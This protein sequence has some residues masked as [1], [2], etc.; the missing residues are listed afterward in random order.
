MRDDGGRERVLEVAAFAEAD[1][2]A[3]RS[4]GAGDGVVRRARG[5]AAGRPVPPELPPLVRRVDARGELPRP[6]LCRALPAARVPAG[7]PRPLPAGRVLGDPAPGLLGADACGCSPSCAGWRACRCSGTSP[8]RVLGGVPLL[9]AVAIFAVSGWPTRYGAEVKPYSSDLFVALALSALADRVVAEARAG[10]LAL[11]PGGGGADGPGLLVPG[12]LRGRGDRPGPA[13]PAWRARAPGRLAAL[14][15]VRPGPGAATFLLLLHTY[16]TAPQDHAYFHA[17]LGRGIPAARRRL[18][19]RWRGSSRSTPAP[20]SPIPRG[21]RGSADRRSPASSAAAF[22][23]WR[24]GRRTVLALC[25]LP[26]ALALVAAA[27]HRYPYG[28]SAA[29]DA[30][31]SRPRSAC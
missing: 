31:R 29:D 8:G 19:A 5:L 16:K 15:G 1:P 26:F 28:M 23:L 10:G 6:R 25:L 3:G 11:G 17:R 21:A 24:R 7:G 12:G 27:M 4:G 30:V 2:W 9:L 20:C 22:V 13:A 18:Q 14:R